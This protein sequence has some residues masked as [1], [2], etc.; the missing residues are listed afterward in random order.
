MQCPKCGAVVAEG[1][2]FCEVCGTRLAAPSSA[3][4]T[5]PAYSRCRCGAG[6]EAVDEQGYCTVCGRKRER[7]A[8]N[9]VELS[10]A[11]HFAGVTDR[12]IRHF[13]NEDDMALALEMRNGEPAYIAVV[14]DGVSSSQEADRASEVAAL[15]AR[16]TL[17]LA[18]KEPEFDPEGAILLAIRA[19]HE[20][21]C[22]LNYAP[23]AEKAPPETTIVAAVVA[24]G[25]A[26][27]GWVGDSRAYWLGTG[28]D[29]DAQLTRDHSWVNEKV[30]SGEMTEE[31]ALQSSLAHAITRSLGKLEHE[32][33]C[34][35]PEAS[36]IVFP[37]PAT[38]R[39]LVCSDG[40]WNYAPHSTDLA[41][42][43]AQAP[44]G[45][46]AL[47]IARHLIEF[48]VA[49]G[50]RDNITAVLLSV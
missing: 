19:A 41:E 37:F 4:P 10:L 43:I 1:S 48:A 30:D 11:P 28:P 12:G 25:K 45:A 3:A 18:L 50:G 13:R 36:V 34:Q 14:C 46:D 16:D 8:R 2:N 44:E 26:T 40:L 21:V 32:D 24:D 29:A 39:L 15:G 9:H 6:P 38:G 35:S 20:A 27:I 23:H 33:T 22:A 31:E 7:L 5:T 42:R 47:G 49:Q 17:L